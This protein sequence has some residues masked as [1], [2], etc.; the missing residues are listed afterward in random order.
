MSHYQST[1]DRQIRIL[2]EWNFKLIIFQFTLF[3]LSWILVLNVIDRPNGQ[4]S[5]YDA[6]GDWFLDS[7]IIGIL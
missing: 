2:L 4:S 7:V 5:A 1:T 6:R 3:S